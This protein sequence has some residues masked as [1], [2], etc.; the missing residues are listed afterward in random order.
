VA[1][2]VKGIQGL[3]ALNRSKF[4]SLYIVAALLVPA[5]IMLG[6]ELFSERL[7]PQDRHGYLHQ[8]D[9]EHV[10]IYGGPY[11]PQSISSGLLDPIPVKKGDDVIRILSLG[12]SGTE[13]WLSAKSVFNQYDIEWQPKM[14][15]S[16]S[17][18]AEFA[19]NS[20]ANEG[21]KKVEIINLGVAAFNASDVIRMMLDAMVLEPDL[22]IFHIGVNEAWT[23]QRLNWP[24]YLDLKKPYF[25]SE[26]GYEVFTEIKA[27]WKTQDP[28]AAG[29][30]PAATVGGK[31]LPVVP[32]PGGRASGMEER[33]EIYRDNLER[34]Y[35][36][37]EY[38]DLPVLILIPT[39]N[40]KDFQPFGSIAKYGTTEEQLGHINEL[41][42]A[43]GSKRGAEAKAAYR[44]IL[45]LDDGIAEAN[46]QYG[47]ILLEEGRYDE[48]GEHFML[49]ADR[50]MLNKRPTQLFLNMTREFVKANNLPYIDV[51]DLFQ[52]NT[53]EGT[54]PGNNWIFD[55]VHPNRQGQFLL[56]TEIVR[57]IVERGMLSGAS[58]DAN[59]TK[60]PQLSDYDNATAYDIEVAATHSLVR[61]THN[62]SSF[63]RFSRRLAWDTNTDVFLGPI[64]EEL[65]FVTDNLSTDEALHL[66]V[67]FN[68]L[69]ANDAA[70]EESM[71]KLNCSDSPERAAQ[72]AVELRKSFRRQIGNARWDV[73]RRLGE[74]MQQEG[75]V[76]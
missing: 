23:G 15:S 4:V 71:A 13:G 43:A 59:L 6:A 65:G 47:R 12:A 24:A 21:S 35:S 67:I 28:G 72:V 19:I 39:L 9:D 69:V 36:L 11:Q 20:V 38:Y 5:V 50:D 56:G 58:F 66:G 41:V 46:F 31:I 16:Y 27:G 18:V 55:D 63:N 1:S 40:L 17:Q 57:E 48:A 37:I 64:M 33:A 34:L 68:L 3:A 73:S 75:C 44:Q 30:K 52:S 7:F 2:K 14:A 62:F 25:Y 70:A 10:A 61:V 45:D 60:M 74:V 53:P 26:L 42:I 22:L 32:E 8:I 76:Q 29:F 51:T 54:P 49:A